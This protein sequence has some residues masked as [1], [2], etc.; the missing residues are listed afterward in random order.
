M[1]GYGFY[2]G[3][4]LLSVIVVLAGISIYLYLKNKKTSNPEVVPLLNLIKYDYANGKISTEEYNE[5]REILESSDLLNPT[6]LALVEMYIRSNLTL[7]QV[8]LLNK[9]LS[10]QAINNDEIINIIKN[11]K[12]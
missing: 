10:E 2:G 1:M 12:K 4:I 7:E 5:K 11:D 8:Y 6:I 3:Y 9:N